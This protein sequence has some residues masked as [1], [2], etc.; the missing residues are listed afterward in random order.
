MKVQRLVLSNFRLHSQTNLLLED[1]TTLIVGRNNSGKTAVAELLRRFTGS[2]TPK[3]RIEDFHA[4]SH[5]RFADSYAKYRADSNDPDTARNLLPVIEARIWISYEGDDDPGG[6]ISPFIIDLDPK[7]C[8]AI[9]SLRYELRPSA[10][11]NLFADLVDPDQSDAS[12]RQFFRDLAPRVPGQYAMTA[13]AIDPTDEGNTKEVSFEAV[14]SAVRT[15]FVNAQRGLDDDTVKAADMLAKVLENLFAAADSPGAGSSDQLLAAAIKG[16]VAEIQEKID[17]DFAKK[18]DGLMPALKTF[19]YPG[20]G[21]TSLQTSTVLEPSRLL[22]NF[23]KVNYASPS[24]VALPE[25]YN[26]LGS[27]NLVFIILQLVGFFKAFRSADSSPAC[28]LI[29]IEEPEAHLHPQMQEVF[30]RQLDKIAKLLVDQD[31]ECDNWPVQFVVSTHS[32]H[33]ANEA[34]FDSIRYF[35]ARAPVGAP[36]SRHA[37]VR[38]L[39]QGL[40][41]APEDAVE[42]LHQYLTLTRCDLFFADAAVL[43]EGT[44]ERILLPVIRRK[45]AEDDAASGSA[46]SAYVSVIEVGGTFAHLFFDLLDFLELPSLIVTDIDAVDVRGGKACAVHVGTATSNPC[47]QFWFDG[48]GTDPTA[49]LAADP[50]SKVRGCK[51]LAYQVPEASGGPCGRTFEDAFMLANPGLFGLAGTTPHELE[52]AARESAKNLGKKSDFALKHALKATEWT[53]P[54]YLVDGL[55]WLFAQAAAGSGLPTDFPEADGS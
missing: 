11:A 53:T 21:G 12:R 38:D 52:D 48:K 39:R 25:S 23:T 4:G 3:F 28:H 37:V 30:I 22:A 40:N 43:V 41:T 31:S 42:F 5:S 18:L 33:V 2:S 27:R 49:L 54:K 15:E 1:G 17:E 9:I 10:I 24:D 55:R 19:G 14:R 6:A 26:G 16:A 50:E 44:T 45:L 8:E 51:R 20:L 13:R 36:L 46:E 47:I 34:S 7:C 32:S 35:L 29:F